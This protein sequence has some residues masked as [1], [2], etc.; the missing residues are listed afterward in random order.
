MFVF[1]TPLCL[2]NAPPD[3]NVVTVLTV[4]QPHLLSTCCMQYSLKLWL[5]DLSFKL[6]SDEQYVQKAGRGVQER[7]ARDSE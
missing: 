2:Q 6:Q 5:S 3:S 7:K 1:T 4:R